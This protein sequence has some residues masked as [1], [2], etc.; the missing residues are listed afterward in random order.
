METFMEPRQ[1]C[2][3]QF[4]LSSTNGLHDVILALV[5]TAEKY[6]I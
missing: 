3:P 1:D 5:I 2:R 4:I 6:K